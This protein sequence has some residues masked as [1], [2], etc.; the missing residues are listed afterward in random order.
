MKDYTLGREYYKNLIVKDF[1]GNVI[2]NKTNFDSLSFSFK[3]MYQTA[4]E[5]KENHKIVNIAMTNKIKNIT[6]KKVVNQD[7]TYY[8]EVDCLDLLGSPPVGRG[9][10][11]KEAV[12]DW[13]LNYQ[14]IIGIK[15]NIDDSAKATEERRRKRELAK[16]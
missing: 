7:N 3:E 6:I 8:F 9:S 16:R 12:G 14:D 4:A 2:E 5:N 15:V 13:F 1:K 11:L 10:S